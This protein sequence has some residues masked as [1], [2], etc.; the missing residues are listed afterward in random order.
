M[1]KAVLSEVGWGEGF[2][3]PVANAENKALEDELQRKQ[4]EKSNV[5][6]KIYTYRDRIQ[7]MGEHLKNV[8]QELSHTQ[9]RVPIILSR[10]KNAEPSRCRLIPAAQRRIGRPDHPGSS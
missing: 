6:N 7:A 4:K 5:E 1:A 9:V 8:R 3:M 2:A 10:A